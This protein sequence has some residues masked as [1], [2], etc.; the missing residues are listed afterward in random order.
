MQLQGLTYS[1]LPDSFLGNSFALTQLADVFRPQIL[2]IHLWKTVFEGSPVVARGSLFWERIATGHILTSHGFRCAFASCKMEGWKLQNLT[3]DVLY[4]SFH[5]H[6]SAVSFVFHLL[7]T[8]LY[9][10]E[11]VR[12]AV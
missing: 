2:E 11:A 7:A 12:E 5:S 4:G 1:I 10:A 6:V 9:R 3:F 8:V